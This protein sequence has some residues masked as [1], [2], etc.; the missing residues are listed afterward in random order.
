MSD[1][2]IDHIAATLKELK[3]LLEPIARALEKTETARAAAIPAPP[4]II[5]EH[6]GRT[7]VVARKALITRD[8]RVCAL[9][10]RP[11]GVIFNLLLTKDHLQSVYSCLPTPTQ[12]PC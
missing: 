12:R 9:F 3:E 1:T 4:Q 10:R 11:S 7:I 8:M 5:V 6:E 2:A